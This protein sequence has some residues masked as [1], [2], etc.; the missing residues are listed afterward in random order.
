M[1]IDANKIKK[2]LIQSISDLRHGSHEN[3]IICIGSLNDEMSENI[4]IH[5][6]ITRDNSEHFEITSEF[7]CITYK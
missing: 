4:Q 2:I 3:E 1:K 6:T 5:L 7:E